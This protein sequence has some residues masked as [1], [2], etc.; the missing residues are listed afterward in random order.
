MLYNSQKNHTMSKS[1]DSSAHGFVWMSFSVHQLGSRPH[2]VVFQ[3]FEPDFPEYDFCVQLC[4]EI[5]VKSCVHWIVLKF[6]VEK[7]LVMSHTRPK[8]I[9]PVHCFGLDFGVC[10][11][12]STDWL[13]H[14]QVN[15]W[16]FYFP[17]GVQFR[18]EILREIPSSCLM[19]YIQRA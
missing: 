14:T 10:N 15:L 5:L 9:Y 18:S 8:G 11:P 2:S 4:C 3:G 7:N 12:T 13:L 6:C 17:N 1:G 19:C 16:N